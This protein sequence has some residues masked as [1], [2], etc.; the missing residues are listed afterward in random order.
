MEVV[1]DGFV[2]IQDEDIILTNSAFTDM[3][4]YE[5]D[6]LL[7]TPFEDLIDAMS[8][9]RDQ[10]MIEALVTGENA[11]RF[12]TRLASKDNNVLHVEMISL[13]KEAKGSSSI[14]GHVICVKQNFAGCV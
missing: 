10:D 14:T 3:L 12:I 7:D 6:G 4:G 13:M 2:V 8:R 5:R 9:R 1:R 11:T